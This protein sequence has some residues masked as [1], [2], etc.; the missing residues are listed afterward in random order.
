[1]YDAESFNN[2][3]AYILGILCVMLMLFLWRYRKKIG[4]ID[5]PKCGDENSAGSPSMFGDGKCYSCGVSIALDDLPKSD[6]EK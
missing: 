3:M 1:M 4:A 2:I 6:L 5:C